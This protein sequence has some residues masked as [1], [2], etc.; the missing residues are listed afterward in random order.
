MTFER[1]GASKVDRPL[2]KTRQ[3]P[4]W[5]DNK[6]YSL[7]GW[8]DIV[9]KIWLLSGLIAHDLCNMPYIQRALH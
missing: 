5:T 7:F 3:N 2:Q 6:A 9:S 8:K 1:F 4:T